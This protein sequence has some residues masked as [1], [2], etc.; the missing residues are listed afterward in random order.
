MYLKINTYSAMDEYTA[1]YN[2][3]AVFTRVVKR[4][5]IDLNL[6]IQATGYFSIDSNMNWKIVIIV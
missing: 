6:H 3:Y 1:A 2:N 5:F 4:V